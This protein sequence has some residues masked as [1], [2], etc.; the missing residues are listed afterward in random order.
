MASAS[1]C[2]DPADVQPMELTRARI[3][4]FIRSQAVR[5]HSDIR[6]ESRSVHRA[7]FAVETQTLGIETQ[8]VQSSEIWIKFCTLSNSDLK[9][10]KITRLLYPFSAVLWCKLEDCPVHLA[11]K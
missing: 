10:I 6:G 4:W 8:Q 7:Y 5:K 2:R 9:F 3:P 1:D 11:Q